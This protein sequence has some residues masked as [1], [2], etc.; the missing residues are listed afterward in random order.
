MFISSIIPPAFLCTATLFSIDNWDL[1]ASNTLPV[2]ILGTIFHDAMGG[3]FIC[4]PH[5]SRSAAGMRRIQEFLQH[6]EVQNNSRSGPVTKLIYQRFL[7]ERPIWARTGCNAVA[8][9][10]KENLVVEL[11]SAYISPEPGKPAILKNVTFS[12]RRTS[13]VMLSAP[14]GWGKST[15]L[16]AIIG[17][18][19]ITGG[20]M[21]VHGDIAYCSQQPW[22]CNVSVQRNIVGENVLDEAWYEAVI[23]ACLLREDLRRIP[24]RDQFV[25]G[26]GGSKLS[27]GQRHR[28]VSSTP[29]P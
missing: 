26:V 27:G 29:I 13:L 17:E 28:V 20:R 8:S 7:F 3:I 18:T 12:I 6:N 5:L 4:Y 23:A 24:L 21:Y 2:F 15:L 11:F 14:M 1:T 22:L 25:V 10:S 16:K 19:E 9:P